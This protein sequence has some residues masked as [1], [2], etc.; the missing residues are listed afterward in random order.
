MALPA[1]YKQVAMQ[2][3]SPQTNHLL[4]AGVPMTFNI[5]KERLRASGGSGSAANKETSPFVTTPN[6]HSGF[7]PQK[8]G[9]SS[10]VSQYLCF[11]L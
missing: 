10:A 9:K 5:L 1:N 7:L 11:P 3:P 8:V 6:G 2:M 4:S